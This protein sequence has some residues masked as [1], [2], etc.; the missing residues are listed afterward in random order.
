MCKIYTVDNGKSNNEQ[1]PSIGYINEIVKMIEDELISQN[2]EFA[3]FSSIKADREVLPINIKKKHEIFAKDIKTDSNYKFISDGIL[4]TIAGKPTKFEVEQY[5]DNSKLEMKDY[6]N[7]IYNR[8]INTPNVINKLRDISTILNDDEVSAGLI[9]TLANKINLDDFEYHTKSHVHLDNNDRKA[10]NILL[11]CLING[12]ADWNAVGDDYNAIKNKPESL[13]ANGGNSDTVAN[14]GIKD[15]IN[16][17]DYDIVVGSSLERYSKDSCD[18]YT[19]ESLLNYEDIKNIIDNSN[20]TRIIYFKRGYY[21]IDNII[22]SYKPTMIINGAD[23]RL[24]TIHAYDY[25][26]FNNTVIKNIGFEDS[27]VFIGSDCEFRNV[28]FNNCT[29]VLDNCVAC[30]ISDCVFEKCVIEYKG[31]LMNNIIKFNRY[32]KTKPIVYVGGNNIITEN[33]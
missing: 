3:G 1:I 19:N 11:K 31:S 13:P 24:S 16:R 27:V 9:N 33:I 2:N 17:D 30:N 32:I 18:I 12:F 25:V 23:C 10:L 29:I 14:H 7:T 20:T 8:I 21:N 15:L 28:K 4:A 26:Q 5:I 22:I 6:M